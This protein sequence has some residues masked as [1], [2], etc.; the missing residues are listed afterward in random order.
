[1]AAFNAK[2]KAANLPPLTIAQIEFD[3]DDQPRGGRVSAL[4]EGLV[5]NRFYGDLGRLEATG[6]KD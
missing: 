1:M 2:L 6:E 3:P 4:V 5:G